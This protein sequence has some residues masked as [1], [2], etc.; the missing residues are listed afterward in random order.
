LALRG[1]RYRP[2]GAATVLCRNLIIYGAGGLVVPFAGIKA[3]D[4]ILSLLTWK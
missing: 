4:M 1:V 2:E 3:I